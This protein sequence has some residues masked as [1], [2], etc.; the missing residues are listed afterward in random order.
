VKLP[1]LLKLSTG[2]ADELPSELK[3]LASILATADKYCVSRLIYL[4]G[5]NIEE[6]LS[7]FGSE[8][9]SLGVTKGAKLVS[10]L[11]DALYDQEEVPALQQYQSSFAGKIFKVFDNSADIPNIKVLVQNHPKLGCD[12]L[13]SRDEVVR[14]RNK[15]IKSKDRKMRKIFEQVPKTRRKDFSDWIR[16]KAVKRPQSLKRRKAV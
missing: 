8:A 16:R 7:R 4:A 10:D 15:V 9:Q 14:K 6:R 12:M 2:I 5:Q 11:S 1:R 3:Y 13:E